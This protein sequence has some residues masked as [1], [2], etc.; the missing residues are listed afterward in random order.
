M[1][2][3]PSTF[4]EDKCVLI[5]GGGGGIGSALAELVLSMGARVRLI[6]VSADAL[7]ATAARLAGGDR[8]ETRVSDLGS[9]AACRATLEDG[10]VPYAV[11]HLAGVSLTDLDDLEDDGRW[12]EIFDANVRNGYL[13]GRIFHALSTGTAETPGRLVYASSLAYRRGGLDRIAYS[14]AKGAIAGMV[15]AMSRR[16]SPT[17]RVNAVAPGV[18]L[19][20]MV[21]AM[22]ASRGEGLLREIPIGRFA[23]PSEVAT[24]IEFL[25]SPASI[26]VNGQVINVDGGT[27][28]S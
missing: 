26:Y 3:T 6:D 8:V 22:L 2:M 4:Y 28:N 1:N 20:P 21:T 10:G 15:R 17:V 23:Q 27:F 12:H 16:F 25:L 7:A 13:L 5:T 19:T 14:S 9:G 24:V 11:V 18:I